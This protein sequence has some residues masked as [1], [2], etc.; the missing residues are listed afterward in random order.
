M[1]ITD[2]Q[3]SLAIP[4][5]NAEQT[6]VECLDSVAAQSFADLEVILI[7]DGS[8]D[9]SLQILQGYAESHPNWRLI[10]Q[11]N[12]GQYPTRNV[13][14]K[15]ARGS[16]LLFVDCDDSIEPDLVEKAY[17]R[18]EAEHADITLFGW[19]YITSPYE[20]PDV[21]RWSLGRAL[22]DSAQNKFPLGYGYVWMKLYRKGFLDENN[23]RFREEFY[24]K[25]DVIFHWKSMSLAERVAVIP[26]VLYHY[27]V[28]ANSITGTIG[29]KFI[30]VV[31]VMEAIKEDLVEIGDPQN[32]VPHWLPFALGFIKSAHQQCPS[33]T[34]ATMERRIRL[35]LD[36]LR[37][38]EKSRI[39]T[40]DGIEAGTD[41]FFLHIMRNESAGY[42]ETGGETF[43]RLGR[44]W[45]SRLIPARLRNWLIDE[46]ETRSHT[47]RTRKATDRDLRNTVTQLNNIVHRLAAENH[48]LRKQ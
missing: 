21:A 34:K 2:P 47:L 31:D 45:G 15:Q 33:N 23:L 7:D 9:G 5:Y 4:V 16:Y 14:L 40:G 37:E 11:D 25:A 18:A 27:R 12:M 39:A 42:R 41:R 26:E 3:V 32:L 29:P 13:A 38:N 10:R 43:R 44:T 6:L 28:H 17:F 46:L 30:Q 36:G 20:P 1:V 24:T 8:T 48:R 35:F 19:D 22:C